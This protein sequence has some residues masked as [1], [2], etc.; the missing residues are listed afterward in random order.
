[1]AAKGRP[2]N[3]QK[4][5]A[6]ASAEKALSG[7]LS[8]AKFADILAWLMSIGKGRT[9][10]VI[11]SQPLLAKEITKP[12][13]SAEDDARDRGVTE[14]VIRNWLATRRN[15]LKTYPD[16]V[17]IQDIRVAMGMNLEDPHFVA[18]Y[19]AWERENIAAAELRD[20]NRP[21]APSPSDWG[22]VLAK[23]SSS[24][25]PKPAAGPASDIDEAP[26]DP[27]FQVV[28]S[29]RTAR[30]IAEIHTLLGT[31]PM[32]DDD[33]MADLRQEWVGF[34]DDIEDDAQTNPPQC[35]HLFATYLKAL[36]A[37]NG[38]FWRDPLSS[39][40]RDERGRLRQRLCTHV[41]QAL[42]PL[43]WNDEG[44][45]MALGHDGTQRPTDLVRV[46]EPRL[47]QAAVDSSR[48]RPFDLPRNP[49]TTKST[50]A[51]ADGR[52]A[53]ADW[54]IDRWHI[55]SANGAVRVGLKKEKY[56]TLLEL[57]DRMFPAFEPPPR[58]HLSAN[59]DAE[60][61]ALDAFADS[62]AIRVM[63]ARVAEQGRSLMLSEQY[64]TV[65]EPGV[66]DLHHLARRL[67]LVPLA[68]AL[69]P[70]AS[71]DYLLRDRE[72]AVI[73]AIDACLTAID[74]IP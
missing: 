60:R 24:P 53:P 26:N 23:R 13:P 71:A 36:T 62:L 64:S 73:Y 28:L 48:S 12:R 3:D 35:R 49:R 59:D 6:R 39:P 68:R 8:A 58:A 5:T 9:N 37:C 29:T 55:E 69:A 1:M 46:K 38:R 61:M 22:S 21:A 43:I 51:A 14:K 2:S 19:S 7:D 11:W 74:Q 31:R 34:H 15:P 45:A 42:F 32:A 10:G 57:I 4:Q 70:S 65:D 63:F 20:T 30:A 25:A 47:F 54:K 67:N 27:A 66:A 41:L 56:R 52:A 44:W 40:G 16:K 17:Q 18:L 72:D 50:D 33:P